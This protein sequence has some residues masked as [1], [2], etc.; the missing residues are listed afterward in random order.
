M[1]ISLEEINEIITYLRYTYQRGNSLQ[2]RDFYDRVSPDTPPV[3]LIH[4]FLGTR[5]AMLPMELRLKRD[6]FVV[7]SIDLGVFN[8]GDIRRSALR[9]HQKIQRIL[10]E[11]DL[12]KIDVVGHSMGGLIGMYYIKKLSGHQFVRKMIT[13]GTPHQGTWIT[14]LGIAVMGLLAPSVWQMVPDNFFLKELQADPLPLGP[15]YHAIAGTYDA[16]CPAER[17]RL[18]GAHNVEIPCGHAAL[19]TSAKVY[20]VIRDI[21]LDNPL[22]NSDNK[23]QLFKNEPL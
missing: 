6:G 8:I 19:A 18:D 1:N 22:Q 4:G 12:E 5:G 14:M 16:V 3:L 2:A 7:F 10:R 23:A 15:N 17:S 13:L 11:V 21:L 20:H 9:I